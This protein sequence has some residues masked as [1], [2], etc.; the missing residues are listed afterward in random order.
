MVR[1]VFPE[2][3]LMLGSVCARRSRSV[4]GDSLCEEGAVA[5]RGL[6]GDLGS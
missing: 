6:A 4:G 2:L 3:S 1:V 5:D